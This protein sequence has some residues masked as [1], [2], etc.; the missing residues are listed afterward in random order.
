M[1]KNHRTSEDGNISF[2]LGSSVCSSSLPPCSILT[3][4]LQKFLLFVV[5]KASSEAFGECWCRLRTSIA[6]V[7]PFSLC[8]RKAG[9]Q[10]Q[11]S[12]VLLLQAWDPAGKE[13]D[14]EKGR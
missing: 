14:P 11:A 7:G 2:Q 5:A 12:S 3:E 1:A 10:F 8:R 13:A 6:L 4:E 9:S